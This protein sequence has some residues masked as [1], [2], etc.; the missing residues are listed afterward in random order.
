MTINKVNSLIFSIGIR[1]VKGRITFTHVL[2]R[3]TQIT[4]V[5]WI[6]ELYADRWSVPVTTYSDHSAVTTYS[7]RSAVAIS[8]L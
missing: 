1:H 3:E 6:G 5:L 2:I 8:G 4:S 7:N